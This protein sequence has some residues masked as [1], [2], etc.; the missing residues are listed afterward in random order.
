MSEQ[1]PHGSKSSP[2][3]QP[4]DQDRKDG[5]ASGVVNPVYPDR[6]RPLTPP[7]FFVPVAK[8]K[9]KIVL[10]EP[11]TERDK[12][13]RQAFYLI[14]QDGDGRITDED[15]T[16][17]LNAY[18]NKTDDDKMFQLLKT[19]WERGLPVPFL[20]LIQ[21]TIN[22]NYYQSNNFPSPGA[23]EELSEQFSE[24]AKTSQESFDL[25]DSFNKIDE[26]SVYVKLATNS[27]EEDEIFRMDP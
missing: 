4:D 7:K 25:M 6:Y 24:N 17:A 9:N 3:E 11:V 18:E 23:L 22:M 1:R 16:K 20:G 13:V 21:F 19:A 27:D 14:D 5:T 12:L 10:K 2:I 8:G 26:Q 15:V